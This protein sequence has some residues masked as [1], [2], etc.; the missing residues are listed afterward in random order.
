MVEWVTIAWMVPEAA[1]SV[2]AGLAAGSIALMAFGIDSIIELVP[3][4]VLLW[5]LVL[6]RKRT[7][8][9]RRA[10]ERAERVASRVVGW[11]VWLDSP[12]M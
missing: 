9:D 6:E 2:R 11:G 5:R 7:Y 10:V 4:G 3:A 1:V 8:T 12:S